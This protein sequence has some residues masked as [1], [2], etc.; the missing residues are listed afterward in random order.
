MSRGKGPRG[1]GNGPLMLDTD[2]EA[3]CGGA[4]DECWVEAGS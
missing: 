1:K 3:P 4:L 2:L